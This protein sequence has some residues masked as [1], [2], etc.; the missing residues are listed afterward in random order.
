MKVRSTHPACPQP[1]SH[2]LTPGPTR[3]RLR[4]PHRQRH[5]AS[6]PRRPRPPLLL[7]LRSLPRLRHRPALALQGLLR[8]QLH[9]GA[10]L[11]F[12]F[13]GFRTGYRRPLLRPIQLRAPHRRQRQ[14]RR[15]RGGAGP[16]P[17]RPQAAGAA[18]V[19]PAD[20]QRDGGERDARGSG[21]CG[22]GGGDGGCGAGGRDGMYTHQQRPSRFFIV[23]G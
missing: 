23:P 3:L 17:G 5:H 21:G 22:C 15:Q 16:E 9:R 12:H 2:Q 11:L 4:R 18:G 20:G 8:H 10:R 13:F 19:R 7:A 14:V 1:L 6:L